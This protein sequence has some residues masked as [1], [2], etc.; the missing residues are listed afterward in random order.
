MLRFFVGLFILGAPVICLA[1][2]G[3]PGPPLSF[4]A[5][6]Q[7]AIATLLLI[8]SLRGL[9]RAR[10][11]QSSG[12]STSSTRPDTQTGN[13]SVAPGAELSA[14]LKSCQGAFIGIGAFSG[15][16]NILALTGS[17]FMLE[18]YDRVLPSRSVPTLVGLAIIT[19][20]LFA[21][22]GLLDVIRGRLLVR[23]GLS[24]DG[25]LS[26]RVY[27]AVV[28]L[29][30]KAS[31]KGDGLQPLRDLDSLRSFLSD[32]RT[33]RALRFALDADIP[34][35]DF[36]LS[37]LSGNCSTFRRNPSRRP[38]ADNRNPDA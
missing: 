22:Q 32:S 9:R 2:P 38:D 10:G 11:R 3:R 4:P 14:A 7:V 27:D 16:I 35:R 13:I 5:L 8:V 37:H 12:S 15:I 34:C 1:G 36:R 17:F 31:D 18:I 30:L 29:P 19:G 26:D 28:R 6:L 25:A 33:F 24:V 23:V 20:V 21:F